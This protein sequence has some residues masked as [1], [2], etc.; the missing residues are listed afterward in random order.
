[1]TLKGISFPFRKADGQFPV[2]D[3]DAMAVR[4]NIMALFNVPMRGRI[5]RPEIGTT[6]GS[7][8]FDPIDELFL[9]RM[10][11]AVRS[12]I[13]RGEPRASVISVNI[14]VKS[15]TVTVDIVYAV[16]GIKDDVSVA[17]ERPV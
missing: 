6:V 8:L 9:L 2:M 12:T 14:T 17:L 7:L 4:S 11:S 5:M 10:E 16:N 3:S 15:T 1:M 13:A